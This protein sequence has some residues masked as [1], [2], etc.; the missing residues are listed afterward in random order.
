MPDDTGVPV[1][2]GGDV[3]M[4]EPVVGLNTAASQVGRIDECG[5]GGI[6]L[7]DKG[8]RNPL[9]SRLVGTGGRKVARFG[10]ARDIG[11]LSGVD[12]DAHGQV[13][14]VPPE[15]GRI[16][17]RRSVAFHLGQ[18]GVTET[19]ESIPPVY[20]LERRN[21]GKIR[22]VRATGHVDIPILVEGEPGS[23]IPARTPEIGREQECRTGRVELADEDVEYS[24][25]ISREEGIGHRNPR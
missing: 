19:Y 15:I 14:P 12:G 1:R 7:G 5:P 4:A 11:V 25:S 21:Q 10:D 18:E 13:V 23:R 6:D 22:G 20:R 2:C 8:V 17:E 3:P 9:E 24:A 16:E